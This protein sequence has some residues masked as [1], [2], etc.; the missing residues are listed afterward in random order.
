MAAN[1]S[2]VVSAAVG[3][4]PAIKQYMVRHCGVVLADAQSYLLEPRLAPVAK[5][6][7]M[8]LVDFVNAA[9][10]SAPQSTL[11]MA[12]IDA[13][14][15]HETMFF[16]D[17]PFWKALHDVV[18]PR[19]VEGNSRPLRIWSAACS[20]GQEAYS[21]AML[22]DESF[23]AACADLMIQATDVSVPA[24][25]RGRAGVYSTLEV[26]RGLG[27]VRLQR[28]FEQ[29]SGGFVVNEGLRKRVTWSTHN[30]LGAGLDPTQCD[31]VLCRNVLIYFGDTDRE[32][33]IKRLFAATRSGGVIGVGT[34]ESLLGRQPVAPGLY[35]NGSIQ[36][37]I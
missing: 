9:A 31:M 4:W 22:I 25:E 3:S 11:G 6:Y 2:G 34:T 5:Q 35:M 8:T 18:L 26:N 17:P 19:L 10:V 15:T 7:G 21:L 12:L 20:T 29:A 27:A 1:L 24:V 14:T 16:R 32:L 28:H 33:V 30:L 37:S 13:M 23:S 36:R